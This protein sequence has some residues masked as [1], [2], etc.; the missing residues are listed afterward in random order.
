[1]DDVGAAL[2]ELAAA[3]RAI[4]VR[5]GGEVLWADPTDAPILRDALGTA[6]P[7]GIAESLLDARRRSARSAARPV[8]A[9]P[10]AV[11]RR[12][13]R[14]PGS[15][16]AS[17]W[18]P[19]RCAGWPA[20][21]GSRR[22]SSARSAVGRV[23]AAGAGAGPEFVDAEVLRLLR[24]R[25]LAALR[26]EVE[27]VE[28]QALAGSC[29][30]GTDFVEA[31]SSRYLSA[32]G[33]S[34]ARRHGRLAAGRRTAGRRGP[35]GL[36]AGVADPAGPGLAVTRRRMLDELILGEVLWTGHGSLA[37]DDGWVA[38]HLADTAALTIPVRTEPWARPSAPEPTA[39]APG[40]P[41]GARPGA[42]PSSSGR[43]TD[44]VPTQTGGSTQM[45]CS[46]MCCGIWS[47]PGWSAATRWRRY[48][49]G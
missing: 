18:S 34:D 36:G 48:G 33:A 16:S 4:E 1:M 30:P 11:R 19:M 40:D 8:R 24:R 5:I 14:R 10:R 47:S 46:R 38:L 3:R 39:T 41:G 22:A 17:R 20:P 31:W 23:D 25:S 45:T 37:G 43:L 15:A 35:P 49:P 42:A 21:A 44:A 27:P 12:R 9:H 13:N 26:A 2:A 28:K 6:L 32:S 7:P 29:P